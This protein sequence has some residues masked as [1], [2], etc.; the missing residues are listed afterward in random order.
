MVRWRQAVVVV[1]ALV[2]GLTGAVPTAA[3][4]RQWWNRGTIPLY[5]TTSA[6]GETARMPDGS[7]RTYL[8]VSGKPAYPNYR[9]SFA[10]VS[11]GASKFYVQ[12][13]VLLEVK[14]Y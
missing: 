8:A 2:A 12:N 3:A 13:G 10:A 5:S 4:A 1:V 14:W 9:T 7:V 11:P 6:G